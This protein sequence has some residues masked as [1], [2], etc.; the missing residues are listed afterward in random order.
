MDLKNSMLLANMMSKSGGEEKILNLVSVGGAT[1]DSDYIFINDG[2]NKYFETIDDI[3]ISDTTTSFEFVLKFKPI[4]NGTANGLFMRYNSID[5][6][7]FINAGATQLV[8]ML[9]GSSFEVSVSFT[10]SWYWFK[11]KRNINTSHWE[12]CLSTDGITYD[13]FKTKDNNT[14]LG[15][16]KIRYGQGSPYSPS[17]PYKLN[18]Q[19]DFAG[20]DIIINGQSVLWV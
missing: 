18:G 20:S 12:F 8:P 2:S 19:I 16:K 6:S 7:A 11:V 17:S 9:N 10:N 5:F 4:I 13:I 15:A 3:N 14:N 1:Y